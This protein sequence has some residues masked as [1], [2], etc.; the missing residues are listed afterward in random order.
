MSE[1]DSTAIFGE[2]LAGLAPFHAAHFGA[3]HPSGYT[4][5]GAFLDR[6]CAQREFQAFGEGVHHLLAVDPCLKVFLVHLN[7]DAIPALVLKYELRTRGVF[8][9]IVAVD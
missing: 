2:S 7:A 6:A 1:F 4:E 9:G 5:R 3:G 8:G